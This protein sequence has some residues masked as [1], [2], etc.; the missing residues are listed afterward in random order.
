M[1]HLQNCIR[2]QRHF[3]RQSEIEFII[4]SIDIVF[5]KILRKDLCPHGSRRSDESKAVQK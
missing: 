3:Y 2:R 4:R 1:C 5:I